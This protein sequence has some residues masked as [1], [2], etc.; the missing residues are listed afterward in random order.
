M[1]HVD[2]LLCMS[3]QPQ[4]TMKG[5]QDNFKINNDKIE[6]PSMYLGAEISKMHNDTNK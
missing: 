3:D 5:I 6:E 1:V 4:I 2:D